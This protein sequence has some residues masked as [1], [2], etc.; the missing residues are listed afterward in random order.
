MADLV[1]DKNFNV[2]W[3]CMYSEGIKKNSYQGKAYLV[4]PHP[5]NTTSN[6][7]YQVEHRRL[8]EELRRIS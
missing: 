8:V 1:H 6:K 3:I 5:T 4:F 2:Q 7:D